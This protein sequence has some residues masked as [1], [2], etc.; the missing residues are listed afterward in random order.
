MHSLRFVHTDHGFD[1]PRMPEAGAARSGS[2]LL[3]TVE[4]IHDTRLDPVAP[5]LT[6]IS[7]PVQVTRSLLGY[8]LNAHGIAEPRTCPR[9]RSQAKPVKSRQ[10]L[11]SGRIRARS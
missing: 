7:E 11:K 10:R 2:T 8:A 6:K 3:P 4:L 1:V 5:E 9:I